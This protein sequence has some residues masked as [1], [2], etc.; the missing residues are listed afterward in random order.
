[1]FSV[2]LESQ[3]GQ[4]V[5][6]A[7]TQKE[8]K[9]MEFNAIMQALVKDL[10]EQMRPM[11]A[12]MVQQQFE[13]ETPAIDLFELAGRIDL[14]KLA[15]HVDLESAD[16]S[17]LAEHLNM[18]ELAGELAGRIDLDTI[19]QRLS[20][21]QL[22]TVAQHISDMQLAQ[23]ANHIDT[24]QLVSELTGGQLNDI[25][26]DIDLADLAGEFDLEKLAENIDL[27]EKF[28]EFFD[29]NTFSI[30]T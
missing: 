4:A 12:E 1:L 11:V 7:L 17:R 8:R 6:E 27:H 18:S 23:I 13:K 30:R 20:D 14:E 16:L 25:A 3:P 21:T 22:E 10:A 28:K 24:A 15:V 9:K 19:A 29:D 2:D 26:G 5:R